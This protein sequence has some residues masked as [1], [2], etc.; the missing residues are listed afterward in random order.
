MISNGGV[1]ILC[2][3]RCDPV[4]QDCPS[5]GQ[6]C[7]PNQD[8]G[9]NF[10]CFHDASQGMGTQGVGCAS[11][12]ACAPGFACQQGAGLSGCAGDCCTA[13]CDTLDDNC[14]SIDA[15]Y[16]C[17]EWFAAPPPEYATSGVCRIPP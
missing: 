7:Y 11:L 3:Q 17:V 5:Q 14:G 8:G 6:G 10:V 1:L 13:Y 2:L 9:D 15:A 4:V 12:N 16:A